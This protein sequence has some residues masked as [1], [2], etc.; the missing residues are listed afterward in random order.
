[1]AVELPNII[2]LIGDPQKTVIELLFTAKALEDS[3]QKLRH[4]SDE[5]RWQNPRTTFCRRREVDRDER[6]SERLWFNC[7]WRVWADVWDPCRC[8]RAGTGVSQA[9]G[10]NVAGVRCRLR[11][12]FASRAPRG[13]RAATGR[14]FQGTFMISG[15]CPQPFAHTHRQRHVE[16]QRLTRMPCFGTSA[17]FICAS[18]CLCPRASSAGGFLCWKPWF[19]WVP[20]LPRS[21]HNLP[22]SKSRP[23]LRPLEHQR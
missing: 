6:F 22:T 16:I 3:K 15:A 1:M 17:S 18:E 8:G 9:P 4:L 12:P 21:F 14:C 11:E 10:G 5:G 19:R 20:W 13:R 2:V 7:S 23:W